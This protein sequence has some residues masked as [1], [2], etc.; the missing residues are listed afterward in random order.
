MFM[1]TLASSMCFC[2]CEFSLGHVIPHTNAY[3]R[4]LPSYAA[5]GRASLRDIFAMKSVRS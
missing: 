5:G 2:G 3:Q 4:L 1:K